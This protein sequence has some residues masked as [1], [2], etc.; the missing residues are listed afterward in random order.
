M[1]NG[2]VGGRLSDVELRRTVIAST[3]IMHADVAAAALFGKD[4]RQVEFLQAAF[5][6]K[7]GEIEMTKMPFKS[8][9]I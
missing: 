6:R 1:R 7:M 3:H 9:V 5:S 2:P 4:P 8:L